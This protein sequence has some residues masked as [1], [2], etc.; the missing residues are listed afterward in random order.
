MDNDKHRPKI[1][2]TIVRVKGR[3]SRTFN[4]GLHRGKPGG[5]L[6]TPPTDK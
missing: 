2:E 1:R 6:I 5:R 4:V 3:E